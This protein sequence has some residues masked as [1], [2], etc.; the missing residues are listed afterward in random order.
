MSTI[1]NFI[2]EGKIKQ[3]VMYT[4]STIMNFILDGKLW[5]TETKRLCR[6]TLT[7]SFVYVI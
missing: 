3:T 5:F 2:L 4:Y 1:M 7:K 6:I